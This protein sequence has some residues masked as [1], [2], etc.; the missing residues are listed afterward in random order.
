MAEG[1]F[2]YWGALR[3]RAS[4]PAT[5]ASDEKGDREGLLVFVNITN[6]D[7]ESLV[8]I[9]YGI[10]PGLCRFGPSLWDRGGVC[11]KGE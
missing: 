4:Q 7:L 6:K 9:V 3:R 5:L 8:P 11:G 10:R 1:A 2:S